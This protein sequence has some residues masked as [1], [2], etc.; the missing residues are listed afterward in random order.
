[1]V[2]VAAAFVVAFGAYEGGLFLAAFALGGRG[3]FTP[4]IIAHVALLNL[5]WAV[6]LIGICEVLRYAKLL[7]GRPTA[8]ATMLVASTR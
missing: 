6:A 2:A 3:A 8:A 1:M 4:A 5:G 7:S